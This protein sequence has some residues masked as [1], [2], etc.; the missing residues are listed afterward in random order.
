MKIQ[1]GN[2]GFAVAQGAPKPQVPEGAFVTNVEKQLGAGVEQIA[3]ARTQVVDAQAAEKAKLEHEANVKIEQK[4]ER[5]AAEEKQVQSLTAVT[6]YR[7]AV[8]QATDATTNAL[9]NGEIERGAAPKFYMDATKTARENALKLVSPEHQ[10]LVGAHFDELQS[11]GALHVDRAMDVA[12]KQE[13]IGAMTNIKDTMAKEAVRPG[14]DVAKLNADYEA[15]AR[16]IYKKAGVPEDKIA[17]DVQDFKDSNT[18]N[19]VV[20]K[21]NAVADNPKALKAI[22]ADI[23]GGTYAATLDPQKQNALLNTVDGRITHLQNAAE[24][25]ERRRD[26]AATRAVTTIEKTIS[27]GMPVSPQTWADASNAT[28]GTTFAPLIS[29]LIKQERETQD[30]LS[31]PIPDQIA[32]VNAAEAAA[33]KSGS[34]AD[35]AN[36]DRLKKTIGS[37]IQTLTQSPLVYATQRQGADVKPLSLDNFGTWGDELRN[38]LNVVDPISKQ[39]GAPKRLL[40]PQEAQAMAGVLQHSTSVQQSQMFDEL[41]K[42]IP[43]PKAY[44]DTI[45]QIAPDQPVIA[46]AGALFGK[47]RAAVREGWFSNSTAPDPKLVAKTLL[48]GNRIL[49]PSKADKSED[50]NR[51]GTMKMPPEKEFDSAFESATRGVYAGNSD[52]RSIDYQAVR[53]YYAGI[54]AKQ[55]KFT[56]ELDDGI[57]RDAVTAVTGG[58]SSNYGGVVRPYGWP[59]D[60]FKDSVR[61]SW[62]AT[63][64][65][66]DLPVQLK[67]ARIKLRNGPQEG[68]YLVMDGMD[69]MR[70]KKGRLIT[71]NV[72][73]G[74]Q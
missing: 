43:D 8:N 5:Q 60:Q 24:A 66:N 17:K 46:Y 28:K 14:A 51:K 53:A 41:H 32:A 39:F 48:E 37:N 68:Q 50:G 11:A 62:L 31:K 44:R 55:G 49:S 58:I 20:S 4:I 67:D 22:K 54:A 38:R 16:S 6:Q 64:K 33:I 12:H 25:Q 73:P 42:S 70:D 13:L 34:L 30:L 47:E 18:F 63:V 29:G 45:A 9:A 74:A 36:A 57:V 3:N 26:A 23:V 52:A 71:I 69:A 21:V 61:N 27:L 1:D 10:A 35:K 40:Y 65:A 19:N 59:E 7:S 2:F 56:G 15:A 72:M